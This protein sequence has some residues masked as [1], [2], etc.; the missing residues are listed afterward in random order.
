M[1]YQNIGRAQLAGRGLRSV[2]AYK[3]LIEMA[4]VA[5]DKDEPPVYFGGWERLALVLGQDVGASTDEAKRKTALNAVCAA[6]Q[7]LVRASLIRRDR[8]P[9]AKGR[10]AAY[11]LLIDAFASLTDGGQAAESEDVGPGLPGT[12]KS[13]TFRETGPGLPGTQLPDF[14]GPK[15][16]RIQEEFNFEDQTHPSRVTTGRVPVEPIT[17]GCEV[18]IGDGPHPYAPDEN[19]LYCVCGR[20]AGHSLHGAAIA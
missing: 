15:D 17:I 6:Q 16:K 20:R 10:T 11:A 4:K 18:S 2:N 13:R 1:G 8:D 7:V 9:R 3:V 12:S 5:L 19:D 14:P